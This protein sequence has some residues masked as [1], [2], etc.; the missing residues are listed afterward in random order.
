M[1]KVLG[2][3]LTRPEPHRDEGLV[4]GCRQERP[5]TQGSSLRNRP[6]LRSKLLLSHL[7]WNKLPLT[8]QL[9][10]KPS[11]HEARVVS[12]GDRCG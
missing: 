10:M 4:S 8:M 6:G 12:G 7:G 11:G 2:L 5:G 3:P 9:S 1:R